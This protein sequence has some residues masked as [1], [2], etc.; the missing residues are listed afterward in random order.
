MSTNASVK[1]KKIVHISKTAGFFFLSEWT[2][3]ISAMNVADGK[4]VITII[5]G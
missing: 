3:S 5:D 2:K 4:I 1:L